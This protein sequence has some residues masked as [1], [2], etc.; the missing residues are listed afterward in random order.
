MKF[1]C[2]ICADKKL[3]ETNHDVIYHLKADHNIKEKKDIIWCTVNDSKCTN[4]FLT[5]NG[6]NKHIKKCVKCVQ[7][8]D[9]QS[10]KTKSDD[11]LDSSETNG[12]AVVNDTFI[13]NPIQ[14]DSTEDL[15]WP[16]NSTFI[17]SSELSMP[18]FD[19]ANEFVLED[20]DDSAKIHVGQLVMDQSTMNNVFK[21]TLRVLEYTR[22]SCT[23]AIQRKTCDPVEALDATMEAITSEISRFNTTHKR[24]HALKSSQKYIAPK[25]YGIGTHTA[26][27]IDK[28]TG[29]KIPIHAQS[30]FFYVPIIE[31]LHT[32]FADDNIRRE[33]FTYNVR[34]KHRCT[35]GVYKD[36]CCSQMFR[37][38]PLFQE[39]PHAIQLQ[40]FMDAFEP[41]SSLKSK[42]GRHSLLGMY[43]TIRNM[44]PRYAYN[45]DNIHLLGV[46]REMDLKKEETDYSNIWRIIVDEVK[47][48][49]TQGIDVGG[50]FILKGN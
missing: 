41:C 5:F 45:F 9:I 35:P 18:D 2:Y 27:E 48:L 19:G 10:K 32:L 43:F 38:N 50:G 42:T 6:L 17:C 26:H 36:F 34:S 20:E 24:Q 1:K 16:K 21:T 22:E 11:N 40:I 23:N 15:G 49:E 7:N 4:H 25:Q 8:N 13:Y 44:P 28:R 47:L 37:D 31:R 46:V 33:Y 14:N 3:F 29:L 39:Q 30:T 12:S